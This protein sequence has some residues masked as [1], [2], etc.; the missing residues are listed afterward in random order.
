MRKLNIRLNVIGA[1]LLALSILAANLAMPLRQASAQ[2]PAP[3]RQVVY[4]PLTSNSEADAESVLA[5]DQLMFGMAGME[6]S[7]GVT[8]RTLTRALIVS[9]IAKDLLFAKSF[10]ARSLQ[11]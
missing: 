10:K 6:Q 11:R 9:G 3:G 7:R 2:S 5:T 1:A 4:L 8:F